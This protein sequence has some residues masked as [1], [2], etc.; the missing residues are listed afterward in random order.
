[1]ARTDLA[2]AG[3]WQNVRWIKADP[4]LDALRSRDDF[5][6]LIAELEGARDAAK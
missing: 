3:G 4:D 6:G 2:V 5:K 1:M